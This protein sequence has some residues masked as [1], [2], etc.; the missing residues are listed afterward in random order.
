MA[1]QSGLNLNGRIHTGSPDKGKAIDP[2]AKLDDWINE[3]DQK[4]KEIRKKTPPD[5]L[6]SHSK[7]TKLETGKQA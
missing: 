4:Q 1:E 6:Q 7:F 2:L 3:V 5:P